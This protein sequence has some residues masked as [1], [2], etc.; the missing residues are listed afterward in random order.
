MIIVEVRAEKVVHI[1]AH[2]A[3]VGMSPCENLSSAF[4]PWGAYSRVWRGKLPDH[5]LMSRSFDLQLFSGHIQYSPYR[6]PTT[7]CA[8]FLFYDKEESISSH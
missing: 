7:M 5:L 1:I 6:T 2:D 4:K 3:K 8:Q